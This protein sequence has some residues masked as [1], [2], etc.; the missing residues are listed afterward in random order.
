MH[1]CDGGVNLS[2]K[3]LHKYWDYMAEQCTNHHI[4]ALLNICTHPAQY[5]QQLPALPS[6][7]SLKHTLGL[8]PHY[9]SCEALAELSLKL[10]D[11]PKDLAAIG[12]TGLDYNRMAQSKYDQQAAFAMQC[13]YA[14]SHVLPIYLHQREAFDDCINEI[15]RHK[16]LMGIAHCFTGNENEMSAFLE[17][18]WYIGITGWLCDDRRNQDLVNAVKKLPLERLVLETDAPYL[19]PRNLR[20]K[21]KGGCNFPSYIPHI[22]QQ[23]SEITGHSVAAIKEHSTANFLALFN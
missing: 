19:T 18:G 13:D 9:A 15:D 16:Q 12:E 10:A 1:W 7:V 14:A 5:K 8:H 3:R 6:H 11:S 21:P 23:L 4:G 17:R 20:P 2:D 22:A